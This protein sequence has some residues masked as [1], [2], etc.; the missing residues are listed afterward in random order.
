MA[1]K[2][3]SNYSQFRL[4]LHN[5]NDSDV[6]SKLK[7]VKNMQGY[8][9]GLIKKDIGTEDTKAKR[10]P[11]KAF[12][13]ITGQ[14]FGNW[15]VIEKTDRKQNNA[16]LWKCVC[17]CGNVGYVLSSSLRNGLSTGCQSCK[18]KNRIPEKRRNPE[19]FDES[20]NKTK[21][22]ASW[23]AIRARCYN[24]NHSSYKNYGGRGIRMC[25][26]WYND[27][28]LFF[29]Y[30]TSLSDYEKEDYTIDRINNDGNY[31]PGNVRW[32]SK[33]IQANNKRKG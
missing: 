25:D 22:Y 13:D 9:K 27:F 29:E 19:H 31:E 4:C 10:S 21:A 5:E 6:I 15:T 24:K 18:W 17:K 8:I 33:K 30:V 26:E 12:I 28:H 32:A 7:S 1:N 11:G 23:Q 2:T 3:K 14:V 16:T 20:G